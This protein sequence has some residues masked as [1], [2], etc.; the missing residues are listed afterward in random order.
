[1]S[2]V[3]TV[4]VH[5]YIHVVHPTEYCPIFARIAHTN[6]THRADSTH[7]YSVWIEHTNTDSTR[8]ARIAHTDSM[9]LGMCGDKIAIQLLV[10]RARART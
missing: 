5:Q 9:C 8:I 6:S 3:R 1:M 10:S 2:S 7:G 4:P